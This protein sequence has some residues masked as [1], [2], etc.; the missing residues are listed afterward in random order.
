MLAH[1][2]DSSF[3]YN[4]VDGGFETLAGIVDGARTFKLN[5]GRLEDG[6]AALTELTG[7]A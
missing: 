6:V 5:F 1:L 3:N 7:T 2:C 4:V